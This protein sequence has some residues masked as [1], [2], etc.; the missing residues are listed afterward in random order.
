MLVRTQWLY[1]CQDDAR[2]C[3]GSFRS[4]SA[5]QCYMRWG[6]PCVS[7]A[8]SDRCRQ[9]YTTCLVSIERPLDLRLMQPADL[10]FDRFCGCIDL[11]TIL[12]VDCF[13]IRSIMRLFSSQP[14]RFSVV[15]LS[16]KHSMA[17]NRSNSNWSNQRWNSAS[18]CRESSGS[19]NSWPGQ[20]DN[21]GN[22]QVPQYIC[23]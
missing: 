18:S 10:L 15:Q 21:S 12:I 9:G 13:Q 17:W 20:Q 7:P 22:T 4:I 6:G 5:L 1:G 3:P 23:A 19:W 8:R 11:T 16:P 14:S 2:V